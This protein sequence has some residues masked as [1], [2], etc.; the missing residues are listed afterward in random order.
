MRGEDRE[1]VLTDV[2]ARCMTQALE[3]KTALDELLAESV[4]HERRRL[5]DHPKAPMAATDKIMLAQIQERLGNGSD[6][7]LSGLL[8][9]QFERYAHEICGQFDPRIYAVATQAVPPA[10]GL[11][12]NASSPKRLLASLPRLPKV[13]DAVRIEGHTDALRRL[14]EVGTVILAPTH[15]SNLDSLILGLAIYQLGLPPALYGAGLN[16]IENKAMGFFMGHLG[17]YKVDRR[18]QDP[19][20]KD[21]LKTFA[22]KTLELGYNHLFF[23]AGTRVRS[24][25]IERHL[26]LGLLGTGVDAY[27]HNLQRNAPRPK[28]FVVPVT[29]SFQLVL[30]AETLIDDF[31]KDVGKARYII[32]DDEFAQP[33]RVFDFLQSAFSLDSQVFVRVG[34][35]MDPFGNPVDCEGESLSPSGSR[36]DPA[37]F[38]WK[39]GAPISDP[40]RDKAYAREV[41]VQLADAYGRDLVVQSTHVTA[42]AVFD[43]LRR[44]YPQLDVLRLVRLGGHENDFE[45]R[46][47]CEHAHKLLSKLKDRAAQGKVHLSPLLAKGDAF[48]VVA[49]GLRHFQV[50]HR[51]AALRRRGDRAICQD[52]ALLFYYQ[53]RLEGMGLEEIL[54]LPAALSSD[55]RRLASAQ[56]SAQGHSA[57]H[58]TLYPSKAARRKKD[59]PLPVVAVLGAGKL[60]TALVRGLATD[61]K[62][63]VWAR[64]ADAGQ[65]MVAKVGDELCHIHQAH[66]PIETMASIGEAVATASVVIVATPASS[67][68]AMGQALASK[69]AGDHILLHAMRGVGSKGEL[70]HQAFRQHLSTLQVGVLGGPL[71]APDWRSGQ[72]VVGVCASR[73]A[74]VWQAA[75]KLT[76]HTPVRLH[77]CSDPI[78]V[79]IAGCMTLVAAVGQGLCRSLNLGEP[80]EGLVRAHALGDARI[81]AKAL[82]AS[83]HTLTQLHTWGESSHRSVD[84]IKRHF[85]L[86]MALGEG[87]SSHETKAQ[88][89]GELE[90][91]AVLEHPKGQ[92]LMR[93][94]SRIVAD[95]KSAQ[96]AME[97]LLRQD[98]DHDGQI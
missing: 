26:K 92:G 51:E 75:Q 80:A 63:H 14:N 50:Y 48:D 21:A 39:D 7:E 32:T 27:V 55:H 88:L 42:R 33:R 65:K 43:L 78:A 52:R 22:S 57:P 3:G 49:D 23:P 74:G 4:Y 89:D 20:Y 41:G 69:L 12:L 79:E 62:V 9:K 38:V 28:I 72:L 70:P 86:G 84:S 82:G 5:K 76:A 54:G 11:L 6:R 98:V 85:K 60:A 83:P 53:N 91:L 73:F 19:L 17:A 1:R 25:A 45:L 44:R 10:L 93:T 13:G 77:G 35:A 58:A 71:Y 97:T 67:M 2:V 16:L 18:K 87:I 68:H 56:S 81:W 36:I 15:V 47:V 29:L 30:E 8:R 34:Q 66:P 90:A 64:D 61:A 40:L 59:E 24:G 31:L 37:R 94:L 46:T 96:S 95:P